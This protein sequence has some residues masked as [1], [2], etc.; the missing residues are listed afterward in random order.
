MYLV[1]AITLL[2]YDSYLN[3]TFQPTRHQRSAAA[4]RTCVQYILNLYVQHASRWHDDS[5]AID[6]SAFL[7]GPLVEK[8]VRPIPGYV[9]P[10]ARLSAG[11]VN[12]NI[13]QHMCL[14]CICVTCSPSRHQ[15]T[16]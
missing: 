9:G 14:N 13:K 4:L 7:H 8:R 11:E 5:A 15:T 3:V 6:T 10:T 1:T 2:Q 16:R 12:I